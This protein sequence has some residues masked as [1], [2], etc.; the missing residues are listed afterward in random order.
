M[1]WLLPCLLWI[2]WNM[3]T[4]ELNNNGLFCVPTVTCCSSI[5][6]KQLLIVINNLWMVM[7]TTVTSIR[8]LL[9]MPSVHKFLWCYPESIQPLKHV[10]CKCIE[11]QGTGSILFVKKWC[12][13][14]A[15]RTETVGPNSGR[16]VR[17]HIESVFLRCLKASRLHSYKLSAQVCTR[18][19][20]V[21]VELWCTVGSR[22]C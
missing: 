4:I 17:W 3:N 15:V 20:V 2:L 1:L 9:Y 6:W 18:P 14:F 12:P 21:M 7:Y 19:A 5:H 11:W 8:H 22:S 13:K 10:F 16:K